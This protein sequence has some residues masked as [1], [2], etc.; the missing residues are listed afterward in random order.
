[1]L[2]DTLQKSGFLAAFFCLLLG[3]FTV[4]ADEMPAL[5]VTALQEKARLLKLAEHPTWLSLL[6]ISGGKARIPD[7]NF[8]LGAPGITAQ[9]TLEQTLALLYGAEAETAVCR[10]PARQL[11]LARQLGMPRSS[12][13]HCSALEEFRQRA[14]MET[15]SLVFASENLSQPSSMM[16]HLLLKISGRDAQQR[17]L[18]HAI[19]FFTDTATAN[20]PKLFYE[21]LLVGK[22]GYY[23]LS[24]YSEPVARYLAGEQ[25]NIWEYQLAL[26]EPSRE[27]IQLHLHELRQTEL[28]YFFDSYNCATLVNFIVSL[29]HPTLREPRGG[30]LTPLDVIKEAKAAG[31]IASTHVQPA[32]RWLVRSLNEQL[33]SAARDEVQHAVLQSQP[34]TSS[35]EA[36]PNGFF[37]LE[38]ARAYNRYLYEQGQRTQASWQAYEQQLGALRERSHT[39]KTLDAGEYKQPTATPPDAQFSVGWR[40]QGE[41]GVV[42]L[43]LLPA[44]HRLEDDNRQYFSENALRLF[45]LQLQQGLRDGKLR[46]GAL[47]V[48][49]VESLIPYDSFTQGWSGRFE[50]GWLPQNQADLRSR[51][52]PAVHGGLGLSRRIA[53]D[54]DLYALAGA[55]AAYAD[56]G[57]YL[58][59]EP[60]L[61]LIVREIGGMKSLLH[62]RYHSRAG[63]QNIGLHS[64]QAT[65]FLPIDQRNAL[66]LDYRYKRRPGLARRELGL[67]F[68]RYF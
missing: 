27:L 6:H 39:G 11:W 47:T 48:Y 36:T 5:T 9:A 55:S 61:G 25:R 31:A 10:F 67:H 38:L 14:P 59:L 34:P 57:A 15:A 62:Y 50:L 1:M 26:D 22:R 2:A 44:S 53:A 3:A 45:E 33:P 17:P 41:G 21:S 23:T 40:E 8:Q 18:A 13:T 56:K 54:V 66:V 64:W 63:G 35:A 51:A 60:E 68:K 30:W 46:L 42:E 4:Q 49:G 24:P 16:G 65:Q 19:S 7:P 37:A 29:A 12:L 28:T 58:S 20:L 43:R 32:S 52:R